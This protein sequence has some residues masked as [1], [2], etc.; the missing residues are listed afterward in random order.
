MLRKNDRIPS[1]NTTVNTD[2]TNYP[3]IKNLN[4]YMIINKV[5]SIHSEDRDMSKYP[6]SNT[7]EIALPDDIQN[8]VAVKLGTYTF[9]SIYDVFV[10]DYNNVSL[11]FTIEN[12]YNP[13]DNGFYDP[14][15]D[16][17]Y[18]A[19]YSHID[20]YY[21]LFITEGYYTPTQ[22]ATE[23]T[24][25]FNKTVTNFIYNYFTANFPQYVDQFVKSGGYTQFVVVYNPVTQSLWFGNKSSGFTITN[26]DN[27]YNVTKNIE[28]AI[29]CNNPTNINYNLDVNEYS[30]WG[31][32]YFL[33][34]NRCPIPSVSNY[35]AAIVNVPPV[36][37]FVYPK[38]NYGDA[39][40]PGDNGYWLLP[41]PSYNTTTVYFMESPGKI[42]LLGYSH[43]YMELN[44]LNNIDESIPFGFSTEKYT[45][46]N[47]T[48]R[49]THNS[50][51][52]K[53]AVTSTPVSQFYDTNS[54]TISIF[55]P[56]IERISKIKVKFRYHNGR[57]V[58]FDNFNFS[59]NLVFEVLTPQILR[60]FTTY[61]PA[62]SAIYGSSSL[63]SKKG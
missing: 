32:P 38:F 16:A 52:A 60:N 2:S 24:N 19:L 30:D 22:M 49:G 47:N 33:G 18:Q 21:Y 48:N 5:V 59:F 3:I 9:P 25:Q 17:M 11:S 34:F 12:P 42:N 20:D 1:Q 27:Y 15:L 29:Y 28:N 57:E 26:D 10:S 31:L 58:N 6:Q 63:S 23:L 37:P 39:L 44:G 43:I 41:D 56:P 46:H 35:S 40:T 55:N 36:P 7:F 50:A 13:A 51:F 54:E 61:N 8:I 62:Q 4:E 45:S 53:I 14:Y